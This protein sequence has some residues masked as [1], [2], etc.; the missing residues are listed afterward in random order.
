MGHGAAGAAACTELRGLIATVWIH[1]DL[2]GDQ[3]ELLKLS[4][5]KS[6]T[7]MAYEAQFQADVDQFR[8]LSHLK[9]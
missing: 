8:W 1:G 9:L 2:Q 6:I 4:L 5:N 3:L 7:S